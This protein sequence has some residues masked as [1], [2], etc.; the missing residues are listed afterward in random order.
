YGN[1]FVCDAQ[2]NLI[3]RMRLTPAGATFHAE[4]ADAKT[5]F[6]RSSDNW[7][8]PVNLVNAPDGTLHVLDMSREVIEAIHI[9]L[10]VVKHLDLRRGRDQGR[11][12]RIAPRGFVP[13][14]RPRLGSADTRTL[15]APLESPNGWKRD[16][17]HRLIF[18]RQDAAAVGP[19]RALVASGSTPQARVHA[20]WSL[21]GLG[22]LSEADLVRALG[23][24]SSRVVEHA[25]RL[26]EP[27]LKMSP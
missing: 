14:P 13:P 7:F 26:A 9:P 5:E 19:L 23:D 2:N 10:D 18:E 22:A 24:P 27:R 25:I 12:Y 1:A 21:E 11:I 17:A 6:V 8:R 20:L 3:H 16:P 15:L 4:R